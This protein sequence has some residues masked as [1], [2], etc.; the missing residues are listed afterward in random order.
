M[1]KYVPLEDVCTKLDQKEENFSVN[2]VVKVISVKKRVREGSKWMV[3]SLD[4]GSYKE[5]SKISVRLNLW[6]KFSLLVYDIESDDTIFIENGLAR[7][8][9]YEDTTYPQINCD[10]NYGSK[11]EIKHKKERILVDG[12]NV[13]YH[14]KK[15]GK[16]GIDSIEM[17]R[18]KLEE[19]GYRAIVI[20]DANLRHLVSEEDGLR[21]EKWLDEGKVQQ[22]PSGIKADDA[23]LKMADERKLR[24]VSN[25]TFRDYE[26]IFLWLKDKGRRISFNIIDTNVLLFGMD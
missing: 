7:N 20:V 13:A 6:G 11:V 9:C 24:I 2:L 8:Y 14:L 25:D 19:K 12:S 3:G 17:V 4:V 18:L 10:E 5:G 21:L 16:P 22:T 23:L 1:E 15:D 26:R